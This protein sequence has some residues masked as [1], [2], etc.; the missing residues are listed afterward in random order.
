[1]GDLAV[2]VRLNDAVIDD[3]VARVRHSVRIGEAADAVVSFPGADVRV[4]RVGPHLVVRGR[5]LAEGEG[6]GISL[7]A[8]HVTVAHTIRHRT[9][10]EWVGLYDRRFLAVAMLL[11]SGGAWMDTV[12]VQFERAAFHEPHATLGQQAALSSAGEQDA[13]EVTAAVMAEGP[14]H[15]SDDHL[16]GM[17]WYRWYRRAVPTDEAQVTEA[18]DRFRWNSDDAPARRVLARD[19]YA[20]DDFEQAAWH[21]RWLLE[22]HPDDH[23]LRLRL[24][25]AERRRGRHQAEAELYREILATDPG[26]TQALSGL[27]LSL[28]R[29][30]R[31]DEAITLSDELQIRAPLWPYTKVTVALLEVMRGRDRAGMEALSRAYADRS[32][33][34]PE[35]RIELRRDL[36]LDPV[37]SGL[38]KDARLR[39]LIHRHLG[40]AGPL[41][42]R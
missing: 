17:G 15:E 23:D 12:E 7:G 36:A 32:L 39:S 35:L 5:P 34:P 10:R 8:A 16:T 31:L 21:Y 6:M 27:A 33:L 4:T 26:H 1:M 28:G 2:T 11:M 40:A 22:R 19:A 18:W 38:R 9:P 20:A 3:R 13:E 41:P 42:A 29:Q 24:A 25:W 30:G 14:R 37:L